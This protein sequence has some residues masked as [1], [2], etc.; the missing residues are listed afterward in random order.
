M[1]GS[2]LISDVISDAKLTAKEKQDVLIVH[3][4]KTIHW[5]VGMKVGRK[6]IASNTSEKILKIKLH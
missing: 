5:C 1:K 4:D 2:Q 6:A 3:D